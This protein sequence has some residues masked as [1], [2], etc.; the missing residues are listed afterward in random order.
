MKKVEKNLRRLYCP[1]STGICYSI[2]DMTLEGG[3]GD[4]TVKN[5]TIKAGP[6]DE[7]IAAV[8]KPNTDNY[9]LVHR[10]YDKTTQQ[11]IVYVWELTSAGF[12]SAPIHEYTLPISGLITDGS[13]SYIGY[14]KFSSDATRFVSVIR[15]SKTVVYGD[16]DPLTG[17]IS[18]LSCRNV[19]TTTRPYGV[20]FSR[21]GDHIYIADE[22]GTLFH[23]SWDDLCNTSNIAVDLNCALGNIQM[24]PDSRIYGVKSSKKTLFVIM[25]PEAG[26]GADI[27]IFDDFFPNTTGLGLPTFAATWFALNLDGSG[28]FCMNDEQEFTLTIKKS[29]NA[30]EL[31][32]TVWDFGDQGVG[33][34]IED[35]SFTPDNKQTHKYTYARPGKYT[36]SVKSYDENGNYLKEQTMTVT[37]SACVLPVN[38]NI[39]L[40][41]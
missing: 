30:N 7:N 8:R 21:S 24:G 3:L 27:R 12:S 41:K 9:W 17:T 34:V 38:P 35:S 40:Y 37:V 20:E 31:S 16:F 19:I 32:Y 25:D 2:V 28:V 4:V 18:D 14:L 33:S 23:I 6:L 13:S 11:L 5:Q 22:Y 29:G 10:R 36:I 39:H 26:A 1:S 15:S